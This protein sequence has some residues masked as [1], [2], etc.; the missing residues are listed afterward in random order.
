M[1]LLDHGNLELNNSKTSKH[2]DI[3][4]LEAEGP[5]CGDQ[6]KPSEGATKDPRVI[7][8]I[9]PCGLKSNFL[10]H[11]HVLA[12][13]AAAVTAKHRENVVVI[14]SDSSLL[15]LTPIGSQHLF[16]LFTITIQTST[17]EGYVQRKIFSYNFNNKCDHILENLPFK[18]IN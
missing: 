5:G 11:R 3:R 8:F 9:L 15:Y 14:S 18:H 2:R 12:P 1:K 17:S 13:F 4:N 16:L 10:D 7:K 6:C